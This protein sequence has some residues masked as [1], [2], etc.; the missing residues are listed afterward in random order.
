MFYILLISKFLI[1]IEIRRGVISDAVPCELLTQ[2]DHTATSSPSHDSCIDI[3]SC[4]IL[5]MSVSMFPDLI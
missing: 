3:S 5:Q 1:T 4:M 2:Q